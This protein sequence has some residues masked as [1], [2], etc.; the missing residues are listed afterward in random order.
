M[1]KRAIVVLLLLVVGLVRLR[2]I[3]HEALG[4]MLMMSLVGS[5]GL[6][7]LVREASHDAAITPPILIYVGLVQV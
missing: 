5:V 7:K 1:L 6:L 4:E 3:C 2:F